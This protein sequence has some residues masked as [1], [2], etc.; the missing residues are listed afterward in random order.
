M[1]M[2]FLASCIAAVSATRCTGK[3][4]GHSNSSNLPQEEC[5]AWVDFYDATGG[6][7]WSY[8][9]DTQFDPCYCG[10]VL[11]DTFGG[12]SSVHISG[13]RLGP[14]NL[15]GTLPASLSSLKKLSFFKIE[16]N[17]LHGNLPDLPYNNMPGECTLFDHSNAPG[18]TN[19]FSCPFPEHVVG[20]CNVA[21]ATAR[22]YRPVT[23]NDCTNQTMQYQCIN[24]KCIPRAPGIPHKECSIA[25]H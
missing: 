18:G 24:S 7:N 8:C 20:N 14:T 23:A 11:C 9:S 10:Y 2:A 1:K 19:S 15:T 17:H 13:F 21:T 5:E 4:S 22:R 25:C 16:G 12:P 3:E 6:P